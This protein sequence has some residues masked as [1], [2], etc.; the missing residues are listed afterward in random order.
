MLISNLKAKQTFVKIELEL[1][2]DL[3]YFIGSFN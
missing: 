1:G 2:L 3:I